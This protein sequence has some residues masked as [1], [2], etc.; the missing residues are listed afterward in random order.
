M[1][2][3][4]EHRKSSRLNNKVTVM[5]ENRDDGNLYYAT[6]YNFSGDGMYCGCD[7]ALKKGTAVV[8]KLDNPPFKSAPKI[9]LGEIRR[10]KELGGADKSH[11]YGLGIKINKAV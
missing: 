4:F 1:D 5:I 9:F 7:F 11:V 2:T 3:G 10:C 8:I 6:M